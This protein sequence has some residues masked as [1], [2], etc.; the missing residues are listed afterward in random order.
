VRQLAA[1]FKKPLVTNRSVLALSVVSNA[2]RRQQAAALQGAFGAMQIT[3]EQ[4]EL[5]FPL[6]EVS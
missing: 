5:S 1:A 3:R 4:P 6:K 2:S